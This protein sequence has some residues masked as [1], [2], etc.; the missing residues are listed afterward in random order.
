[1]LI[2][3]LKA[4]ARVRLFDKEKSVELGEISRIEPKPNNQGEVLFGFDFPDN[5]QILRDTLLNGK[6]TGNDHNQ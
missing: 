4:G 2:I 6:D 1:M 5:I 3:K